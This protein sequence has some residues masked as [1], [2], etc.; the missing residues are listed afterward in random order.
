V[1][2]SPAHLLVVDDEPML[3]DMIS[4][5]LRFAGYEVSVAG[6]GVEAGRAV[7]DHRPDLVVLD[8]NLPGDD[9]FLVARQLRSVVPDLAVLF[10]TARDDTEDLRAGF[11]AGG[12]DYLTKPFRLEELRLRVEAILRRTR[13]HRVE[14]G[15]LRCAD[16]EMDDNRHLVRRGGTEVALTPTEYR[17]LNHLLSNVGIVVTRDRLLEAV[18]GPGYGDSVLETAVSQLRKKIDSTGPKLLHT[19]RGFGYSLRPPE[20]S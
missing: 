1:N 15:V 13:T 7:R 6:D 18:W 20:R 12:D 17:L 19:V 16:L 11:E 2:P 10:L 8:V 9:G 4:D 14:S 5:A 3:L